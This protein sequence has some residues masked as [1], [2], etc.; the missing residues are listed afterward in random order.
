MEY[1]E[2]EKLQRARIYLAKMIK[3]VNPVSDE[4]LPNIEISEECKNKIRSCLKYV[5]DVLGELETSAKTE[6]GN[7]YKDI[8]QMSENEINIT[9][10]V[11]NI[12]HVMLITGRPRLTITSITGWLLENEYLVEIKSDKKLSR[13]PTDKARNIGI[14]SITKYGRDGRPYEMNLYG[15]EAQK[16]IIS[17]LDEILERIKKNGKRQT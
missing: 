1:S 2:L 13:V 10:F 12:N 16:F 9:S 7:N 5:S 14:N 15:F 3:G 4:N 17:S 8:I 6:Y 11:S